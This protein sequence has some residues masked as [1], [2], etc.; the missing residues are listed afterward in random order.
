M[1]TQ[2]IFKLSIALGTQRFKTDDRVTD[3]LT[4]IP[5]VGQGRPVMTSFV[6]I[7]RFEFRFKLKNVI[8]KM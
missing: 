3:C 7:S 6:N 2:C 8:N 1:Y 4:G 5:V